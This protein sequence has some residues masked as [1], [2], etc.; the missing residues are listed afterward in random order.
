MACRRKNVSEIAVDSK[1]HINGLNGYPNNVNN[2]HHQ[3]GIE[4]HTANGHSGKSNGFSAPMVCTMCACVFLSRRMIFVGSCYYYC[5]RKRR[6]FYWFFCHLQHL[7]VLIK[8]QISFSFWRCTE[9]SAMQW[10]G[11]HKWHRNENGQYRRQWWTANGVKRIIRTNSIDY[12]LSNLLGILCADVVG[13]SKS[14]TVQT[15]SGNRKESRRESYTICINN[16]NKQYIRIHSNCIVL[17][18]HCIVC[19][20]TVLIVV[21]LL[22]QTVFY[23]FVAITFYTNHLIIFRKWLMT[24]SLP[25]DIWRSQFY[26]A[27]HFFIIFS[28][29]PSAY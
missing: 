7:Y 9:I 1:P 24:S 4:R 14:I 16:K 25:D 19:T 23:L 29:F 2:F 28:Y 12:R 11:Q 3:N 6:E 26:F 15:E 22:R 8:I 20:A 5:S 27:A 13:I 21:S 10:K 17:C 18:V